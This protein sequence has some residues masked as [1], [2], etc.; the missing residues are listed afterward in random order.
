MS[1]AVSPRS[2]VTK[3]EVPIHKQQREIQSSYY[4]HTRFSIFTACCYFRDAENNT[5]CKSV[6]ISSELS[7]YSR[8]AVITSV[9]TVIEHLRE[10]HQ[11]VPLKNNSIVWSG[12][13]SAQF[14]SQFDFKLLSSVDTS[15]N[16]TGCY[17]ERHHC[18]GS[19]INQF[20]KIRPV[21]EAKF[22]D[23]HNYKNNYIITLEY[24]I[25]NIQ[26]SF[27]TSLT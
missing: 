5:I 12:D 2:L 6:T 17:N 13:C 11:Y 27:S 20:T 9:L 18:K 7:D 26:K 1:G 23:N 24:D 4:G 14:R 15:L 25:H 8:A 3:N 21:L 10:K 22:G 19:M 16:I